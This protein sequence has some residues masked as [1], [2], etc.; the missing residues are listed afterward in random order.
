MENEYGVLS[1]IETVFERTGF[2]RRETHRFFF[3]GTFLHQW[4]AAV[5]KEMAVL[6]LEEC[7]L[8]KRVLSS[9]GRKKFFPLANDQFL[10]VEIKL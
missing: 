10:I 1:K 8:Q 5:L 2:H 7:Q 3:N 6:V 4:G 9:K